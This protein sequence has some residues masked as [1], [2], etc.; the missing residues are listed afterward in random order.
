MEVK[1]LADA[2][3]FSTDKMMKINLFETSRMF[4]DI[5]CLEPG[6]EQK[7]HAHSGS[8]KI[9]HVLQGSGLFRIG[10]EEKRLRAGDTTM[11]PL[12]ADHGVKN[13]SSERLVLLV[14]MAPHPDP[15][16]FSQ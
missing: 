14:F 15:Q 9:Y 1:S 3:K 7:P 8:D 12:G 16:R 4:C 13:N 5:Y 10:G 11:A 2:L 6:Q